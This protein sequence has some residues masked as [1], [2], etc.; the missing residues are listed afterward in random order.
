MKNALN[1]QKD[2]VKPQ[3]NPKIKSP[4][5][6][7]NSKKTQCKLTIQVE[8][9]PKILSGLTSKNASKEK[10]PIILK[11]GSKSSYY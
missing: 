9:N 6:N 3:E 8:K 11:P 10:K 2:I 4:I 7:D 1:K 5:A